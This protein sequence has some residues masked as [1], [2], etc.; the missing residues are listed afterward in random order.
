MVELIIWIACAFACAYIA[1]KKNR[2]KAVWFIIGLLTG[3][4]GLI[5]ILILKKRY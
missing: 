4:L 5:V 3:V 1:D 2:N